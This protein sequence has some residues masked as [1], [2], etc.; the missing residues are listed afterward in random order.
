MI[1]P[2]KR[3][4]ADIAAGLAISETEL[5]NGDLVP[6]ETVLAD[7]RASLARIEEKQKQAE[8][9]EATPRR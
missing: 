9:R 4:L 5:A 2:A 7:L 8:R 3:T 1:D 6:G